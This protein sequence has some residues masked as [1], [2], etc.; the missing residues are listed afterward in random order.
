MKLK[1]KRVW[2]EG[3][4]MPATICVEDGKIAAM[5]AY[6]SAADAVDFGDNRVVPGFIDVH[7][8][9]AYGA[10]VNYCSDEQLELWTAKLPDEGVTAYLPTTFTE[11]PENTIEAVVK[12]G[13]VMRKPQ[14]GAEILGAHMEGPF[15]NAEFKGA[16][17]P[18]TI[19][20]PNCELLDAIQAQSNSAVKYIT[21]AVEKDADY[22]FTRHAAGIGIKVTIGHSAATFREAM[23]GLANG[24][25]CFTHAF[26]AMRPLNHREPGCVGALMRS[27]AFTELIFDGHHVVAE[28]VKTL[29]EIKGKDRIVG[30]SDS[31]ALKAAPPGEYDLN[32]QQLL[33]NDE[34]TAYIK[35]T[36]T[37]A[38][39]TLMFN[40]GLR[41]LVEE[42]LVPFDWALTA[43]TANP[44]RMLGLDHRLGHIKVGFDADLVVLRDNYDIE[45]TYCKG[46]KRA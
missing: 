35:G 31:L 12:I 18:L 45:A 44:A 2:I 41:F 6:D 4:F 42:A 20:S 26:N 32:G 5:E 33:V 23:M 16:M 8:H 10:M 34:G 28:V 3:V 38:G 19:V 37:L 15:L 46:E 25:V 30:I 27:D 14:N 11:T 21:V 39:S 1:S 36:T 43:I 7:T 22:A 24:A 9:G 13:R 17:N 40:K 29:F